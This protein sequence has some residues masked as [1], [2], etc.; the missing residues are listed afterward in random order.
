MHLCI[1]IW[2]L[3]NISIIY[4]SE[5]IYRKQCTN[6]VTSQCYYIIIC[7]LFIHSGDLCSASSRHSE[8]LPASHGQRRK[9]SGKCK[10]WK[11]GPS[12]RNA[13][14]SML[15]SPQQKRPFPTP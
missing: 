1:H 6:I 15:M 13:D 11:D 2:T 5:H 3:D 9:T 7:Y 12:A 10:I 8:T 4:R 14:H